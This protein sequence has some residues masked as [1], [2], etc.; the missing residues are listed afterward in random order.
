MNNKFDIPVGPLQVQSIGFFRCSSSTS[1]TVQS[2]S[3]STR[4][5]A[6]LRVRTRPGVPLRPHCK[7]PSKRLAFALETAQW[8]GSSIHGV[9]YAVR[10]SLRSKC[11]NTPIS[12]EIVMNSGGY[13]CI[14]IQTIWRSNLDSY[15][16]ITTC[17]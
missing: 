3:E 17:E 12:V 4:S 14:S 6:P 5:E 8:Q 10:L 1:A 2:L 11:V 13:L 15:E 9:R 7:S 16:E